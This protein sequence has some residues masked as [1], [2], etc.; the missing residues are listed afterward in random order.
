MMKMEK[1]STDNLVQSVKEDLF[2]ASADVYSYMS[3]CAYDTAW[4][5]MIPDP[6]QPH[7]PKFP[8]CLDWILANQNGDA[9]FWVDQ[10][11]LYLHHQ[12]VHLNLPSLDSLTATLACMLAL[13]KWDVG[14]HNV[15]KGLRFLEANMDRLLIM[16]QLH[17]P[18][19]EWFS[20][21]FP[22]MLELA[23]A[24]GL[25]V[26]PHSPASLEALKNVFD[27]RETILQGIKRSSIPGPHP[28]LAMYL[29]ALPA[30]YKNL[31]EECILGHQ[32]E[33][34]SLFQSPSATAYAFMAT[35]NDKCMSYLE[36][37]VQRC[38]HGV[39]SVYPVDEDMIRLCM[40]D[41][42][43]SLGCAEHF[44]A[45]IGSVMERA[46]S[47]WVAQQGRVPGMNN[48]TRR[49]YEDSLVFRLL[50]MHG[51]R[52]SPSR[53]C[54]F[55]HDDQ[56]LSNIEENHGFFK[57]AMYSVYKSAHLTFSGEDEL[58]K[59][60][61]FSRKILEKGLLCCDPEDGAAYFNDLQ[62]EILHELKLPWLARMDHIEH[63][64]YIERSQSGYG[65]WIGKTSSIRLSCFSH[66]IIRQLA[67]RN[68]TARQS[69]YNA[70]L[71]EMK[72]WS[73]D[74]GFAN[75]GFGREN[76]AYC[77]YA[78]AVG[79]C[80]PLLT[81]L[82]KIISKCSV[83]VTVADDFF[84]EK[85]SAD[86]LRDL[87]KAVQ[88]WEGEGLS[89]HSKVI[90]DVLDGL[91]NDLVLG[92]SCQQGPNYM[93]KI[94]QGIWSETFESWLKEAEWSRKRHAPPIN[95][96]LRV[97]AVSIAIQAMIL[98]ACF[99]IGPVLPWNSA[100]YSKSIQLLM[101][102]TRLLNDIQSYQKEL[103]AGKLNMVMLY[104]RE[105]PKADIKDSVAYIT[106]ILDE[107]KK[108]LLELTLM[109][110]G[111]DPPKEW[112]KIYL[113]TLKAFQMFFNS[114]N[115][116]DSPTALLEDMS[117]A[118][119]DPLVLHDA[120]ETS[121][122]LSESLKFPSELKNSKTRN[123]RKATLMK[124]QKDVIGPGRIPSPS[125]NKK[126]SKQFSIG[127]RVHYPRRSSSYLVT[128]V[129]PRHAA[130]IVFSM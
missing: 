117:F 110:D 70:E 123:P 88:R 13:K 71:E 19:P 89:G 68:F 30:G 27:Q 24:L 91:V 86:E 114:S 11:H 32:S 87:T 35:G 17:G 121:R 31:P 45:E 16:Q 2:S 96:Y 29:E 38:G 26:Y 8:G 102:T 104:M 52:V 5:A 53:F 77:Y 48:V 81:D 66:K 78:T 33:D 95:E 7:R 97:G 112:K 46:Y 22:G 127:G 73:K 75:I 62:I 122:V 39:P 60:R 37:L 67:Q 63:R 76:T 119:Y 129:M 58:D 12:S 50:R 94:L 34:G 21:I 74:V 18:P 4:L 111:N 128:S 42:L 49:M 43:S 57:G 85:G 80:L 92:S 116:F 103:E 106:E 90:F 51:Y 108:E 101:V 54:W 93:K 59:A 9:G 120:P 69:I 6:R 72:R 126:S 23:Q 3:S 40:V 55:I 83:L 107:K 44:A 99:V 47:N 125:E 115:A 82:R 113:T 14:S 84:D 98:P 109:N 56:M 10:D 64:K 130:G 1:Y 65:L 28:L 124:F 41:H 118:F 15:H 100:R 20:I 36:A 79:S 105:N 25:E 61:T